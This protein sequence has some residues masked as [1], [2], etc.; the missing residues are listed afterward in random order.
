MRASKMLVTGRSGRARWALD[1]AGG[2]RVALQSRREASL[3]LIAFVAL[4][5]TNK[6][7]PIMY[8]LKIYCDHVILLARLSYSKSTLLYLYL[9][10]RLEADV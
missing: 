9:I 8:I 4:E 6:I 1:D 2:E 7:L 5:I 3:A 10:N